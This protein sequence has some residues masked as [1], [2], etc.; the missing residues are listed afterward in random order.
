MRGSGAVG[1]VCLSP[2][3]RPRK[4][5]GVYVDYITYVRTCNGDPSLCFVQKIVFLYVRMYI[6]ARR[7]GGSVHGA[8]CLFL[9]WGVVCT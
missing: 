3:C 6:E 7:K 1:W 4:P 8:A 9:T 2:Q 5:A